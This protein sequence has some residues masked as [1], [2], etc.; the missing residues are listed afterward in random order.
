MARVTGL[1][2]FFDVLAIVKDPVK[3]EAKVGELQKLIAQYTE[4]VEAVVALGAVNDY[5]Q[6]IKKREEETKSILEHAKQDAKD[7]IAKTNAKVEKLMQV[8]L[9]KEAEVAVKVQQLGVAE[10][11]FAGLQKDFDTA[12]EQLKAEKQQLE[13]EKKQFNEEKDAFAQR[14]KK[15]E[16]ALK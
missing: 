14:Q 2:S 13:Q 4:V 10:E 1:D 16:E 7:T 3:Y 11:K 6:N 9:D 12:V 5:T 8:A 15:L